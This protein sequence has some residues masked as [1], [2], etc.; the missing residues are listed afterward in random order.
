MTIGQTVHRLETCTSTND[1]ARVFAEDGFEE[2]FAVLADSQLAG[3]GTKG[4]AWFSP[5]GQGIYL[6]VIL[7]P[8]PDVAPLLSLM[9]GLAVCDAL[10][11]AAG[12][13]VD[14]GWPNDVTW[15]GG[16]LAGVL[17][18][19]SWSG[20]HLNFV[21]VGIG[22]NV[23]EEAADFPEELRHSATSLRLAF[24]RRPPD[25]DLILEALY[26]ALNRW[27]D[28]LKE[29]RTDELIGAAEK[30]LRLER[31]AEIVLETEAGPVSGAFAGLRPDGRL[32]L[33][34]DGAERLFSAS[35]V[36]RIRKD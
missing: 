1:A 5:P 16:K 20:P 18:E 30:A 2:G 36:S 7:R 11:E 31:G 3:R 32:A 27:Y 10:A 21:V 8:P 4:R 15:E 33:G 19:S 25:R 35:E 12:L 22:L 14:L 29:G 23:D 9:A 26:P 6:S 13:R 24:G 28:V 17:S 34:L